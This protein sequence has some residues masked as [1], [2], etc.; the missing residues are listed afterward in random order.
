[1]ETIPNVTP[2]EVPEGTPIPFKVPEYEDAIPVGKSLAIVGGII[3]CIIAVFFMAR[4]SS[5]V[6][7]KQPANDVDFS[8]MNGAKQQQGQAAGMQSYGPPPPS[9]STSPKTSATPS[10]TLTDTPTPTQTTTP[11]PTGTPSPTP[12]NSP[13]NTPTPSPSP[14]PTATPTEALPSPT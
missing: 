1:M 8:K 14:T 5:A 9:A 10:P 11:E 4:T 2:D 3:A 13:T 7:P 12:T 6:A